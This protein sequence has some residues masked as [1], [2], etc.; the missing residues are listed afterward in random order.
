[1]IHIYNKNVKRAIYVAFSA[2]SVVHYYF[3]SDM[4]NDYYSA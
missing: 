1:M 3:I 2:I 4:V